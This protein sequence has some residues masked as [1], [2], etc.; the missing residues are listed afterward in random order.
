MKKNKLTMLYINIYIFLSGSINALP[1]YLF[2][3]KNFKS[4]FFFLF[5]QIKIERKILIKKAKMCLPLYALIGKKITRV[6]LL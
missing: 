6:I 5:S 3:R 4:S 1:D 2:Y